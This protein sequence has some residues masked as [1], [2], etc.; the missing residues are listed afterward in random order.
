MFVY[1]KVNGDKTKYMVAGGAEIY[2]GSL[3][4]NK[5]TFE[6][7]EEFKFLSFRIILEVK[8]RNVYTLLVPILS[9]C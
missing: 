6:K 3:Q 2:G 4:V 1:L 8:L 7:V 5:Y 9:S